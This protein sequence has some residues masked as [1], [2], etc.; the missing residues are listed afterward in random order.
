MSTNT[1]AKVKFFFMSDIVTPL[2]VHIEGLEG[3]IPV[4]RVM[5]LAARIRAGPTSLLSGGT[6]ELLIECQVTIFHIVRT[7]TEYIIGGDWE[8]VL[9]V[10]NVLDMFPS[11]GTFQCVLP[12]SRRMMRGW[13]ASDGEVQR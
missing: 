4:D 8:R 7:S 6:P 9:W 3:V 1:A 11:E 12:V 10:R 2:K 13:V 5:E